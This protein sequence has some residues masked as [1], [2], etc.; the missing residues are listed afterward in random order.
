MHLKEPKI[1]F[2][3]TALLLGRG[4]TTD[5]AGESTPIIVQLTK[6]RVIK[7]AYSAQYVCVF[8]MHLQCACNYI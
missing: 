2:R 8:N 4:V 1:K 7:H 6:G 3:V 5:H